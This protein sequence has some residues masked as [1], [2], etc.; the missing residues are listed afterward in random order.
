MTCMSERLNGSLYL[1]ASSVARRLRKCIAACLAYLWR[2]LRRHRERRYLM[3]MDA[4]M[5]S[6]IGVDRATAW[7]EARK[8]WW[9][10]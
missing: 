5:L 7:R 3:E 6:D 8:W 4:R 2:A 10:V 9:E 1:P